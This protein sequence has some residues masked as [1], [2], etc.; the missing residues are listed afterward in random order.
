[1]S[2][3]RSALDELRV[4]DVDDFTGD[5]LKSELIESSRHVAAFQV[6]H[7]RVFG[8][9]ERRGV[10]ETDGHL[11]ATAW[12]KHWCRLAGGKASGLVRAAWSL[13]HMPLT[14]AAFSD[15]DIGISAV[16]VLADAR[17]AHPEIFIEHEETFVEVARTLAGRQLRAAVAYWRQAL[18]EA[19]ALQD[20]NHA[21]G[22]R[23]LHVSPT[24]GGV[25][26]IDGVLDPEGTETVLTALGAVLDTETRTTS[27]GDDGRVPAQR[28]ADA[29]LHI[30]RSYL[31]HNPATV[32]GERPHLSVVV[33]LEVL[34]RRATGRAETAHGQVLHPETVRRL[35]CD[36]AVSRIIAK[37]QSQPLD[38]GRRTRTI[39]P[40][41]GRAL[42]IRDRH[43][44]FAGCDRPAPWCD[45]H[46]II[47][48]A[49]GGDT[50]LTNLTLLCRR[51]HRMIHEGGWTL[52]PGIDGPEFTNPHGDTRTTDTHARDP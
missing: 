35:A 2:T 36:S 40:A 24:L 37:G 30:C 33:D 42:V 47:H 34:E 21:F 32:A 29:L 51:H 27:D 19:A 23:R 38:V 17:T 16:K 12:L 13:T 7:L 14:L 39:P 6:H 26:R 15:G 11:S 48:W 31:D 46:H 41:I 1:M 45:G 25:G 43:C 3:L 28:R 10:H 20:T 44:T 5:E 50:A 4:V 49:Q 52:T 22:R 8:A 9:F 18:D